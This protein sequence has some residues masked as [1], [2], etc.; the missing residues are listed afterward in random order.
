MFI[1]IDR[2]KLGILAAFSVY[3]LA[4]IFLEIITYQTYFPIQPFN[5]QPTI[6]ITTE[7]LLITKE[8]LQVEQDSKNISKDQND[9][10]EQSINDWQEN[11]ADEINQSIIDY[12]KSLHQDNV[13]KND[14]IVK[15]NEDGNNNNDLKP[16]VL[17]TNNN[18]KT[19]YGGNVMVSWSLTERTA[20]LN[21]NWYVRNPGY[22]CDQD[23]YGKITI[24]IKVD[25]NGS[26]IYAS[27]LEKGDASQCMI[28]QA[29]KYAK[30]SRFNYSTTATPNQ[31]GT[32]TYTFISQ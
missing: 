26:V 32:I 9:L 22:T 14:N 21:N 31:I 1:V 17:N 15:E 29:I 16:Q 28:N 10:R 18:V 8:N 12:E 7:E 6:S 24:Q 4:F 20:Y 3:I 2:H 13:S 25:Q 19:E 23:S 5:D 30:L 27:V 11:K